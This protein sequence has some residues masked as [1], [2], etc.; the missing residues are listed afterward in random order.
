MTRADRPVPVTDDPDTGG[1][2]AAAARGHLAVSVCS[3]CGRVLHLPTPHCAHCGSW[4]V[5]WRDVSPSGRVHSYTVVEQS[6]HPAFEAPY[7]VALIELDDA[8]GAR[9]V[10]YLPGRVPLEIDMAMTAVFDTAHGD[11]VVPRWVPAHLD[12]LR[13]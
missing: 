11:V 4:D 13:S 12:H 10:G 6:V 7:T 5:G 1:F 2:W 8:P 3:N 9:L